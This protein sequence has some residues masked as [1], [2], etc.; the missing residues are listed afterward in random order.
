M[1]PHMSQAV[2]QRPSLE[3]AVNFSGILSTLLW[4]HMTFLEPGLTPWILHAHWCWLQKPVKKRHPPHKIY[5]HPMVV[6]RGPME[7]G[8]M[9]PGR[10]DHSTAAGMALTLVSCTYKPVRDQ[11]SWNPDKTLN[12]C[13]TKEC[14]FF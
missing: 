13:I 11:Q 7:E 1:E 10:A 9:R 2:D 14:K 8:K 4:A 5:W 3:P 6:H 12:L